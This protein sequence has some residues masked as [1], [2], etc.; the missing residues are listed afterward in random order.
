M[1]PLDETIFAT[2]RKQFS[3][4]AW[5][6]VEGGHRRRE[7]IRTNAKKENLRGKAASA[8]SGKTANDVAR[9]LHTKQTVELFRQDIIEQGVDDDDDEE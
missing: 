4:S 6:K 5:G 2:R 9:C 1:N 7:G 8:A 3:Q